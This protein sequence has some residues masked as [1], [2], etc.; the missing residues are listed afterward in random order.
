[1]DPATIKQLV[2]ESAEDMM[3]QITDRIVRTM[4]TAT[5]K[6]LVRASLETIMPQI[7]DRIT[8]SVEITLRREQK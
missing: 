8:R 3:P 4:D 7:V 1:M 6:E 5:I 2:R